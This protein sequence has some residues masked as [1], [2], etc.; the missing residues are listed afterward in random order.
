MRSKRS[1]SRRNLSSQ[2]NTPLDRPEALFEDGRLEDRLAAPLGLLAAARIGVNV[3]NHAAVE[4]RLAVGP[5][6]V[7]TIKTDDGAAEIHA[8]LPDDAHHFGQCLPQK[9][10]F[11]AIPRR[12][13]ERRDHVAPAIAEG[14]DLVALHPLVATEAQ[15]I[16]T[17]FRRRC[18]A[19]TKNDR[20]IETA[21]LMKPRHRASE[22]RVH[23]A[24]VDPAPPDTVNT[25]VVRFR[26]AFAILV[27][28]QLL[29]LTT[30]IQELQ[31]VV[32]DRVKTQLR[33]RIAAT[34][35]EMRQDKL[36]ELRTRQL[37]RKRLPPLGFR[38]SGPPK[39]PALPD[40]VTSAEI[41]GPR[42]PTAN[43]NRLQKPATS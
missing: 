14:D 35:G 4:D 12:H 26:L 10:R 6:V 3:G 32:E 40:S 21:V 31:N 30:Q 1:S 8:H 17:F 41:S 29:P 22:N 11:I 18:R 13:N 16:A 24:V 5:A 37:R 34:D 20:R 25:R 9:R 43:F 39:N 7:D 19:V 42:R 33:C 36:L 15:V 23:A 38:H 28:R 27:D 2:A